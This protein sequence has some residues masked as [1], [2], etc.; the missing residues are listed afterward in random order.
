MY[1]LLAFK[2]FPCVWHETYPGPGIERISDRSSDR[3]SDHTSPSVHNQTTFNN[4]TP[5]SQGQFRG[6]CHVI[7]CHVIPWRVMWYH[8]MSC[9]MWFIWVLKRREWRLGRNCPTLALIFHIILIWWMVMV[10]TY[11]IYII[12]WLTSYQKRCDIWSSVQVNTSLHH[13]K[14][15]I[16]NAIKI[17]HIL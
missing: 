1:S 8:D 15:K 12:P 10:Y 2:T 7:P 11:Y 4:W 13:L 14:F 6:V 9:G 3:S 5:Q 16:H 17:Y